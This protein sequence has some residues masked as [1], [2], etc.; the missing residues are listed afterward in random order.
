[1]LG[2]LRIC[3]HAAN[4]GGDFEAAHTWFDCAYALCGMTCDLLSAANMRAKLVPTSAVALDAYKH[5][6]QLGEGERPPPA[7]QL[8]MA[9]SKL[10]SV[11]AARAERDARRVGELPLGALASAREYA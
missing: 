6:L 8:E 4:D 7:M 3:G 5:I 2:L 10:A 11:E 1:M 9:A